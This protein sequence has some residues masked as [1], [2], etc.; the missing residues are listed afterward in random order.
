MKLDSYV[1]GQ[2]IAPSGDFNDVRSAVTGDVI[3]EAMTG[4]RG[5]RGIRTLA[6]ASTRDRRRQCDG[7]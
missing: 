3:A 1:N 4:G 7:G 6:R 5:L 2:W